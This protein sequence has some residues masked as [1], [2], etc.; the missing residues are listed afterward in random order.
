MRPAIGT[1]DL[2]HNDDGFKTQ[3]QRFA[4]HEFGLRHCPFCAINQQDHPIDHAENALNLC[5]KVGVARR[6][7]DIDACRLAAIF[8]LHAG[9]FGK[10]GDAALF[11]QIARIHRALFH[12][13]VFTEGTRLAEKLIHQRGLA[14]VNVSDDRNIAKGLGHYAFGLMETGFAARNFAAPHN[15]PRA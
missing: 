12:A 14:V 5:A 1:V 9:A 2:V 7:D 11:F 13:L 8:P 3:S 4:G 10:N 15:Q 6:I